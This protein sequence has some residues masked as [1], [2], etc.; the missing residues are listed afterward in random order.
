MAYDALITLRHLRC[1]MKHVA[2]QMGLSDLNEAE[3]DALSAI[4]DL[5]EKAPTFQACQVVEHE[6][7]CGV[8]RTSKYRAVKSLE[9]RGV[10]ARVC[11]NGKRVL[12]L[13]PDFFVPISRNWDAD[14]SMSPD[15]T[16]SI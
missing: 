12:T 8:S 9:D 5:A 10:I 3:L 16:L 1:A 2:N 11:L 13:N 6:S 4:G 7:M 14:K 15:K